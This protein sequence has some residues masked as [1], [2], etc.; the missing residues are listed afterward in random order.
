MANSFHK[1]LFDDDIHLINA[2][3]FTDIAAR[4]ADT[5]FQITTNINKAVRVDSPVSFFILASIGPAVWVQVAAADPIDTFLELSDTPGSYSSQ[6]GNITQVNVAETALE[7]GQKLRTTDNP[8]FTDLTLTGNLLVSG[9]ETKL[10][11]T[12]LVEDNKIVLANI[13]VPTDANA[14]GGGVLLKGS[15]DKSI[16]FS[17]ADNGWDFNIPLFGPIVSGLNPTFGFLTEITSGLGFTSFLG[18][19]GTVFI[20]S[21]NNLVAEFHESKRVSIAG[22]LINTDAAL[23]VTAISELGIDLKTLGNT[24]K[25]RFFED[26]PTSSKF[27]SLRAPATI[28]ADIDFTLPDSFP[29][30]NGEALVSST[31]GILSFSTL[32]DFVTS[33]STSLD[34]QIVRF[35]STTGK[36]IQNSLTTISDGGEMIINLTGGGINLLLESVGQETV[37]EINSDG[38]FDSSLKFKG[39]QGRIKYTDTDQ[40]M[41]F[42][43]TLERVRIL[44]DGKFGINTGIPDT[45]FQVNDTIIDDLSRVYDPTIAMVINQTPTSNTA[46]ND[47]EDVLYL[48]RQGTTGEALGALA[49]FKISRY[50]NTGDSSRTRLDLDLTDDQFNDLNVMTWLS[51]G[52]VGIGETSPT[53]ARL[54][55]NDVN[56]Q[57]M[58]EGDIV[59][60]TYESFNA[61]ADEKVWDEFYTGGVHL[62]RIVNDADS[63]A[64]T[65]L[66]VSRTGAVIDDVIINGKNIGLGTFSPTSRVSIDGSLDVKRLGSSGGPSTVDEVIIGLTNLSMP[67]TVTITSTDIVLG[68]LFIIKD[69]SGNASVT[70][71]ITINPQGSETIDGAANVAITTGFGVVRLYSDGSNLF[72]W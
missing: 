49:T 54:V 44:A 57:L 19:D 16:L 31:A 38:G 64:N 28:V 11:T 50:E 59:R 55:V 52:N 32:A 68:R 24:A 12:L 41:F 39:S 5:A 22:A 58:L 61:V 10:D 9:S 62:A 18:A 67:R 70:N 33:S 15:T 26:F 37:L 40:M 3:T 30:T 17:L 36:I 46:L 23:Q 35:D 71:P 56:R 69:E 53:I 2:R 72:S 27:V 43:N 48:G 6:A 13:P 29:A 4:D 42:T 51:N 1:D 45:R 25:L 63:V 21:R 7:F 65:W 66:L 20:K 8:Q 60:L 47:P 34:N 14:V